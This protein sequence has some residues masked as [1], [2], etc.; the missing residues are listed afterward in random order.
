[1]LNKLLNINQ[2]IFLYFMKKFIYLFTIVLFVLSSC[3]KEQELISESHSDE[4]VYI[5]TPLTPQEINRRID[6]SINKTGD[7][8]WADA[9]AELVWSAAMHGDSILTVGYG[10]GSF[11]NGDK[12]HNE[13][14][15]KTLIGKITEF[16][17]AKTSPVFY[18]DKFLNIFDVKISNLSTVEMIL[19]SEGLRYAEPSG[20]SYQKYSDNHKSDAGCTFD[21][22][23]V[24]PNDYSVIEPNCLLSW[25]YD[26]HNIPAA[27]EY[28]TGA[29]ITV[30]LIDTGVSPY[31]SLLGNNFNNGYSAGRTIEKYGV[32]VNSWWPWSNNT[33]GVDDKCGHGTSMAAT[34]AAPRNDMGMPVG[35]AYNCNFI[36]YRATGDVVLNGYHER[37][38]VAKALTELANNQ[39][40][41]IISMSIGYIYKINRIADAI[42]YADYK[43]K[44]IFAAGGTSKSFTNGAGVIFPANM[45]ETVAVTGIKSGSYAECEVCH[46]GSKIDFTVTMERGAGNESHSVCLGY[47]DNTTDYVGGSSVATATTAGI[48]ALV[49]A[50]HPDWSK[51]QILQQLKEAGDFYPNKHPDFGYGNINA[52]TAVQ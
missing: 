45:N 20:Y 2:F 50:V 1:M 52:L 21:N 26:E 12:A 28:S 9:D 25:T 4:G 49:W 3:E 32:Y 44:L 47:Y 8:N 31:Q 16:E 43:G 22:A 37:R 15:K 29:G 5:N 14:I 11:S 7:F 23:S 10:N 42:K 17:A 46:K 30:G 33:D 18:E 51:A 34:I 48:A 38:G 40:L 6:L 35:V 39:E 24:N 27:W 36:S 13:A 41:R 19:N